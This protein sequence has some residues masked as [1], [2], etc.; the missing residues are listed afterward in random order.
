MNKVSAELHAISVSVVYLKLYRFAV[1]SVV[2]FDLQTMIVFITLSVIN[3]RALPPYY[4]MIFCVH[5]ILKPK[6]HRSRCF[7]T[8]ESTFLLQ[9]DLIF[10]LIH[11]VLFI[12][13]FSSRI[14][15]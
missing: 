10:V 14:S 1:Y 3:V 9:N 2:L 4:V 8:R 11:C 6:V 15:N 12:L 5:N 13:F 7:V